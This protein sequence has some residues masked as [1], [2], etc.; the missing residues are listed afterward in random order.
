[1]GGVFIMSKWPIDAQSHHVFQACHG[2][3]PTNP[4]DCSAA[5]GVNYARINKAGQPYHVLGTHLDAGLDSGDYFARRLQIDEMAALSMLSI[6]PDDQPV[7]MAGDFNIDKISMDPDRQAEYAYLRDTLRVTA[8]SDPWYPPDQ[9]TNPKGEWID[10]V[11]YSN[12]HLAPRLSFNYVL[13]PRDAGGGDL[14]DHY[15]VLGR[16]VFAP[17]GSTQPE[18]SAQPAGRRRKRH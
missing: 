2:D 12:A 17:P 3:I 7:I 14:S 16:F 10:Y 18:T 4:P 13:K 11:F 9:G 6:A 8:P 5:K 1:N 15:A